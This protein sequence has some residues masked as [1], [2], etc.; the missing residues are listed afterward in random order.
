MQEYGDECAP[1][2]RRCV[3][4]AYIDSVSYFRPRVARTAVYHELVAAYFEWVGVARGGCGNALRHT[5]THTRARTRTH[6]C[7]ARVSTHSLLFVPP[8][9]FV[10]VCVCP[11]C[12]LI[13]AL[14]S[15]VRDSNR[16]VRRRGFNTANIWSAPPQRGNTY[17]FWCHPPHQR[18]PGRERLCAWYHDLLER[19][20][21]DGKILRVSKLHDQCFAG[22]EFPF[23]PCVPLRRLLAFSCPQRDDSNYGSH[24]RTPSY[25]SWHHH[26]SFIIVHPIPKRYFEGDFWPTEVERLGLMPRSKRLKA[27]LKVQQEAAKQREAEGK[28]EKAGEAMAAALSGNK[29]SDKEDRER[30]VRLLDR[31]SL[32]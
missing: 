1:P 25:A 14:L 8:G 13:L 6:T 15:L 23:P 5:H 27:Q 20:L 29:E 28:A 30:C 9:L 32:L 11:F 12:S 17:I 18:T 3:Y 24:S 10:F 19:A 21:Q 2:S 7:R 26:S 16:Y 31:S 22:N 4:I